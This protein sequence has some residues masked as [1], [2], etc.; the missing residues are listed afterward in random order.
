MLNEPDINAIV[1][2][3]ASA[4]LS[5]GSVVD[6]MSEPTT[7]SVGDAALNIR[8]VLT[9]EST[10]SVTGD[11]LLNTLMQIKRKLQEAGDVRLPIVRY[12]TQDE[13]AES[14]D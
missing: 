9:P 5:G 6:V 1:R 2:A 4:N 12:A 13:L 8:I 11:S 10:A 14:G 3:A 7:D